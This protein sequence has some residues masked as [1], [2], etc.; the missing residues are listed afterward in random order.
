MNRLPDSPLDGAEPDRTW[1]EA[2]A[3]LRAEL[4]G[5]QP[6]PQLEA[7]LQAAFRARHAPA[8]WPRRL[9]G[10]LRRLTGWLSLEGGLWL[11]LGGGACV[12]G[13]AALIWLRP[14]LLQH[15]AAPSVLEPGPVARQPA[16]LVTA[17][18]PLGDPARLERAAHARMVRVS[19]PREAMAA[20]GLPVNPA[21]ADRPI[22]A[23]L[24]V[25]DDGNALALRFVRDARHLM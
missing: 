14:V 16:E 22:E 3:P 12:A 6:P 20:Y 13:L 7:A 24:L 5:E 9:A 15:G 4:A 19:L 17:F 2:L 21:L 8:P 11:P 18:I 23:D 10:R 25:G 1:R